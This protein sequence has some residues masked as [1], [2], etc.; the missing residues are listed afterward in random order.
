VTS[1]PAVAVYAPKSYVERSFVA[2][3]AS[4]HEKL[5]TELE[6]SMTRFLNS[7]FF[8]EASACSAACAAEPGG[9][10]CHVV[11][12]E[13]LTESFVDLDMFCVELVAQ[14]EEYCTRQ[15]AA[16]L[17]QKQNV[18]ARV[19]EEDHAAMEDLKILSSLWDSTHVGEELGDGF[20]D[21]AATLVLSWSSVSRLKATL[22]SK[23]TRMR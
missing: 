18:E 23:L 16:R 5:R 20:E 13:M 14:H 19:V 21:R 11:G 12:E 15:R 10:R 22:H 3:V 6:D 4:H 2:A 17:Q 7:H 1:P 8:D 9:L